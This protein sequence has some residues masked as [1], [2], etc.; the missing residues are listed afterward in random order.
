MLFFEKNHYIVLVNVFN[1]GYYLFNVL[2][3]MNQNREL[4]NCLCLT[5]H[6]NNSDIS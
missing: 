1:E 3:F 4:G 2:I 5:L 6:V